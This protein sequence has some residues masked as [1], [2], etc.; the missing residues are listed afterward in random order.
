M[1]PNRVRTWGDWFWEVFMRGGLFSLRRMP[2]S[3]AERELE[4]ERVS[5]PRDLTKLHLN[6]DA[7]G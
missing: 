6:D 5:S 3:S 7:R 4:A 1:R 2:T